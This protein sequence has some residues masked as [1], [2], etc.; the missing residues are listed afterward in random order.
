MERKRD[1]EV[2]DRGRYSG[3]QPEQWIGRRHRS[4]MEKTFR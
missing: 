4:V 2:G 3:E 1:I